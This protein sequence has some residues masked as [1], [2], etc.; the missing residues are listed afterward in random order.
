MI[1][2]FRP[3]D[4]PGGAERPF[5]LFLLSHPGRVPLRRER[6]NRHRGASPFRK[7]RSFRG[8]PAMR[9]AVMR[10]VNR[11]RRMGLEAGSVRGS[12]RS[13]CP[14]VRFFHAGS[15]AFAGMQRTSSASGLFLKS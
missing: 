6:R 2:A 11:E 4:G 8:F 7:E 5:R 14:V 15:R 10:A 12:G 9:S 1:A 13:S 3:I